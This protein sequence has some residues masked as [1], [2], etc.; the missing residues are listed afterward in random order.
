MKIDRSQD[1][2]LEVVRANA[3]TETEDADEQK[4]SEDFLKIGFENQF[5]KNELTRIRNLINDS[6]DEFLGN[7]S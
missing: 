3:R 2:A 5:Q 4:L 7:K 6:L 1:S